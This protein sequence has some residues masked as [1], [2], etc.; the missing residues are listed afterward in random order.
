MGGPAAGQSLEQGLVVLRQAQ[1]RLRSRMCRT[2]CHIERH[3][4]G[5]GT[6]EPIG[7][8]RGW[9]RTPPVQAE[10]PER[11]QPEPQRRRQDR[12]G[13]SL[14]EQVTAT[15]PRRL[16]VPSPVHPVLRAIL[17]SRQRRSR[18]LPPAQQSQRPSKGRQHTRSCFQCHH[19]HTPS[20]P[21]RIVAAHERRT[22]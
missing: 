8:V 22:T 11:G 21:R 19:T 9:L 6:Q 3:R 10:Q 1:Y 18:N 16:P 12:L 20:Q 4:C 14:C 15:G 5:P 7:P 13:D 17:F 2:R